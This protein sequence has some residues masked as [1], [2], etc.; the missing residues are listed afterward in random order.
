MEQGLTDLMLP[1]G[2]DDLLGIRV[3]R[4]LVLKEDRLN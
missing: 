1:D 3:A 2:R 4:Q